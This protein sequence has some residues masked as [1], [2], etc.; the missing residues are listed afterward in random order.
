MSFRGPFSDVVMHIGDGCGAPAEEETLHIPASAAN[1]EGPARQA[2]PEAGGQVTS[3]GDVALPASDQP[4]QR[5]RGRRRESATKLAVR[6]QVLKAALALHPAGD[7]LDGPF[8]AV[9]G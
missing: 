5:E 4:P 2:S 3:S 9:G 6:T 8:C 7:V 1:C